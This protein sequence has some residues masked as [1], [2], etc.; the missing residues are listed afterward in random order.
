[1]QPFEKND[2]TEFFQP[3]FL[4]KGQPRASGRGRGGAPPSAANH[5]RQR[6]GTGAQAHEGACTPLTT[7]AAA[8][9][10]P[11]GGC[12]SGRQPSQAAG[13]RETA[14]ATLPNLV[15]DSPS[16]TIHDHSLR[17]AAEVGQGGKSL[18]DE[19]KRRRPS[20]ASVLTDD[21]DSS[22]YQQ[23]LAHKVHQAAVALAS[24][25]AQAGT[26]ADL[27][28]AERQGCCAGLGGTLAG[29]SMP[30]MVAGVSVLCCVLIAVQETLTESVIGNFTEEAEEG[31]GGYQQ[32][33]DM[34]EPIGAFIGVMAF[35]FALLYT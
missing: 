28:T 7:A 10:P 20:L 2:S 18:P 12:P 1:M 31:D 9:F 14:M 4:P 24:E 32:H 23:Q 17:G 34:N 27:G 13:E 8:P 29:A 35:I 26:P 19:V 33:F 11:R 3:R 5:T 22:S 25:E 6:G 21:P 30:I 15:L 16:A